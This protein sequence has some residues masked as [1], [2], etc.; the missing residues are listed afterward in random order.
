MAVILP[1]SVHQIREKADFWG[2]ILFKTGLLRGRFAEFSREVFAEE[3][4]YFQTIAA[5]I[6][7]IGAFTFV[8]EKHGVP[9][10]P[11]YPSR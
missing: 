2:D 4:H 9:D 6:Q 3:K 8:E 10:L 5:G 1:D 7:G 11:F